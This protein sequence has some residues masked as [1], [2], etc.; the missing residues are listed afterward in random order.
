MEKIKA[1]KIDKQWKEVAKGDK[2]AEF[3]WGKNNQTSLTR[4]TTQATHEPTPKPSQE[5]TKGHSQVLWRRVRVAVK[6]AWR[7]DRESSSVAKGRGQTWR[8]DW[9]SKTNL[10]YQKPIW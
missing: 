7:S 6:P 3:N 9:G 1:M 8:S 5:P 4:A 2:S 10:R